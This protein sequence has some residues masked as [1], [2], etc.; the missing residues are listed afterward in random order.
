MEGACLLQGFPPPEGSPSVLVPSWNFLFKH[1]TPAYR[2]RGVKIKTALSSNQPE[3]TTE[4][5]CD[6]NVTTGISG[7]AESNGLREMRTGRQALPVEWPLEWSS[8]CIKKSEGDVT[9][10]S[11]VMNIH[12]PTSPGDWSCTRQRSRWGPAGLAEPISR[13]SRLP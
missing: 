9:W 1:L 5:T 13:T 2:R 6:E 4:C 12:E 11:G 8:S 7:R 3:D 10:T